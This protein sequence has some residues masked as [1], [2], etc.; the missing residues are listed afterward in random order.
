MVTL[1]KYVPE[2]RVPIDALAFLDLDVACG[3]SLVERV[4]ECHGGLFERD[5]YY[6]ED[7]WADVARGLARNDLN[8]LLLALIWHG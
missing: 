5:R 6:V 2:P 1:A 4:P 7:S 3:G 8:A